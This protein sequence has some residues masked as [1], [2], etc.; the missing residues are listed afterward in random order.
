MYAF[1]DVQGFTCGYLFIVKEF[2]LRDSEGTCI[3]Y[4][5][6]APFD[7]SQLSEKDKKSYRYCRSYSGFLWNSGKVPYSDAHLL[8]NSALNDY[9]K[10]YVKGQNKVKWIKAYT[11]NEV[12]NIENLNVNFRLRDC[13]MT[14]CKYHNGVCALRNVF[15]ISF[16]SNFL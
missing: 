14:T 10:I 8:I 11:K 16:V 3:H 2:A 13:K 5:F 6:E 9:E 1:A 4:I 15:L 7:I 12:I